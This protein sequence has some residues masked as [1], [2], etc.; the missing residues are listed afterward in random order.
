MT[1]Q[2]LKM[3]NFVS[4]N[5]MLRFLITS[6]VL[7][8]SIGFIGYSLNDQV[9]SDGIVTVTVDMPFSNSRQARDPDFLDL[10]DIGSNV[11]SRVYD[12]ASQATS[13]DGLDEIDDLAPGLASRVSELKAQAT[14][15]SN[16]LLKIKSL[17]LTLGTDRLCYVQ[18]NEPR[19]CRDLPSQVSDLFPEPFNTLLDI[20]IPFLSTILAIN[21]RKCLISALVGA[22]L[23]A[24]TFITPFYLGLELLQSIPKLRLALEVAMFLL[25][26]VPLLLAAI[27][28]F[29][30][31]SILKNLDWLN[32]AS[33]SLE[34]CLGVALA[35]AILSG[36]LFFRCRCL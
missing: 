6:S 28:T 35:F 4:P 12:A 19:R 14:A 20:D 9:R 23:F 33:G 15:I 2:R 25:G 34:W 11:K 5:T 27:V 32:V 24:A 1:S 26:I 17:K 18:G 3:N 16:P 8:V 31:T 29:S 22:S 30:I 10:G 36:I 7:L 13:V 21:I